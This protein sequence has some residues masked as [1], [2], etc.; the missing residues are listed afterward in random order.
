VA[1]AIH[2]GHTLRPEVAACMAL[3]DGERRREED[4][5]TDRLTIPFS[6]RVVVDRSRFEVDLNRSPEEAIYLSEDQAWGL[7][8]WG[9]LPGPDL[10]ARSLE[11]HEDFY[12]QLGRLLDEVAS[13]GSF[14]VLDL[15]SYNH[16]RDG[17]HAPPAPV[18]ENPDIN[19][20]TGTLDHS[21]WDALVDRF[22][23][24]LTT[25]LSSSVTIAENV[26]FQGGFFSQWVN[27]RYAGRGCALALEFK[28]TFMD[29][30]TDE[31]DEDAVDRLVGALAGTVDGISQELRGKL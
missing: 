30:W 2:S 15:H 24:D 22:A 16:R 8:V 13:Q 10:V 4:P 31:L 5:Y 9:E 7:Q 28:K 26:R 19:I 21:R 17:R 20:G 6:T 25:G 23:N 12:R 3:S 11:V 1:T 29:E 27:E 18:A 14:V